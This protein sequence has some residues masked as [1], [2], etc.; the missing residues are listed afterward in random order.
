MQIRKDMGNIRKVSAIISA[1][2]EQPRISK[3]LVPLMR[4]KLVSEI[5][6]VDDGSTDDTSKEVAKFRKVILIRNRRNF[7]KYAAMNIGIKNAHGN[8]ILCLDSDLNN[9]TT[10]IID[11]LIFPVMNNQAELSLGYRKGFSLFKY[12]YFLAEPY[13]T[14]ERCFKKNDY[15]SI[16]RKYKLK[17]FQIE[18]AMNKYFLDNKKKIA[19]ATCDKLTQTMKFQKYGMLKGGWNDLAMTY[20]IL[21]RFG[22][23]EL[24]KQMIFIS[25]NF[26][27]KY[28]FSKSKNVVYLN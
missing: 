3:V 15:T 24:I 22:V 19:V 16:T 18:V 13:L 12:I 1:F 4:S 5:I 21:T 28:H 26:H 17:N 6:V 14:G 23:W 9:L 11:K 25:L 27:Y 10:E 2:N 20:S 7:G 8:I